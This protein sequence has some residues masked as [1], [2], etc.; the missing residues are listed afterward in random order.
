MD[1]GDEQDYL[2]LPSQPGVV[3]V[4][5]DEDD[6][7]IDYSYSIIWH[8]FRKFNDT[9]H[10]TTEDVDNYLQSDE[11][12]TSRH[13]LNVGEKG[14]SF[15][16]FIHYLLP[17]RVNAQ[18]NKRFLLITWVMRKYPKLYLE[19]AGAGK[20]IL[21]VAL[22]YDY[23]DIK[24]MTGFLRKFI[25]LYPN[26]VV[27][28]L[29]KMEEKD[30]HNLGKVLHSI[31][32]VIRNSAPSQFLRFFREHP[33]ETL[34][35]KTGTK[36][37][38]PSQ[39]GTISSEE[40]G[41]AIIL[42]W[43]G[44][45]PE[46]V[47][48]R[49]NKQSMT[50]TK[51]P[52]SFLNEEK[53]TALHLAVGYCECTKEQ[54]KAQLRLVKRLFS[55]C[56]KALERVNS[57]GH[58]PY[59]QRITSLSTIPTTQRHEQKEDNIAFFLKDKIMHLPDRDNVLDLLYGRSPGRSVREIHLDLR[60]VQMS[61]SSSTRKKALLNFIN[62]LKLESILQ[63]V[64]IS[65]YPFRDPGASSH[66]PTVDVVET[67]PDKGG[68]GRRDFKE[69]FD[70]L[71]EKGVLKIHRLIVDDDD[72]CVHQDEIIEALSCFEIEEF[73]W[74]K[75][76][77]SSSVLREAAPK[78]QTLRLFSSGNYSVLRDW[79]SEDGLNQLNRVSYW[80]KGWRKRNSSLTR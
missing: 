78:V 33:E 19:G 39:Q 9:P 71:K 28:I 10:T 72:A 70:V 18:E 23:L 73:Q 46:K 56:P 66:S 5:S 48:T 75:M 68:T 22:L 58:H 64:Q 35:V 63:C 32:P 27:D 29:K 42:R 57:A 15:A 40:I 80:P 53:Q 14:S 74:R 21:D 13:L 51:H 8:F 31:I 3:K 41:D 52:G 77:L 24:I 65:K 50:K 2:L 25:E 11:V 44:E 60:E 26:E 54:S 30:I 76:D 43:P 37:P 47:A 7:N 17:R 45:L 12:F 34:S 61:A 1:Y 6:H 69:I 62:G 20:S 59:L 16:S 67:K 38:A 79:S 55:W 36:R 49:Q 4:E